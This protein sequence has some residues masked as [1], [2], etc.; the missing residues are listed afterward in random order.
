[1]QD[2]VFRRA[3]ADDVAAIVAMLADDELGRAREAPDPPLDQA[4]A[5]AFAA[6]DRDPNQLLAVAVVGDA[7]VGTL[8]LTFIPGLSHRGAWRGEVEGV[9][10]AT[11]R[12]GTGLG[13]RLLEWAVAECRARGCRIVQLTSNNARLDA[14]RFYVGLG[15]QQ[16]HT[17]FK[18]MLGEG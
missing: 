2:V 7:V 4:Y 6:V 16:S 8:Q 3:T 15:F 18:L 10:I 12:R 17:G 5:A 9:R 11:D 14:H 13:R 1:M